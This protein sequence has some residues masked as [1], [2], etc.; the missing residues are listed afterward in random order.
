MEQYRILNS[1]MGFGNHSKNGASP[2][3]RMSKGTL[4]F[5]FLFFLFSFSFENT[6][7]QTRVTW[8]PRAQ[9]FDL[10]FE[11]IGRTVDGSKGFYGHSADESS[12]SYLTR[13]KKGA[14]IDCW[15]QSMYIRSVKNGA[16]Y[17]IIQKE[18]NG[19][20][21]VFDI[22]NDKVI[23][24]FD[25][26][27]REDIDMKNDFFKFGYFKVKKGQ[28]FGLVN[29]SSESENIPCMYD[30][31]QPLTYNSNIGEEC[32]VCIGLNDKFGV[33]NL[34]N[35]NM[36]IPCKYEESFSFY[37]DKLKT[38]LNNKIILID[39]ENYKE[40]N[41]ESF[42]VK[43]AEEEARLEARLEAERERLEAEREEQRRAQ[44]QAEELQRQEAEKRRVTTIKSAE[45]GD[46]LFYSE[47]WSW[48]ETGFWIVE[49]G[50]YEM[51]VT[52]FIERIEGER[53]QLRIG[54][55]TSSSSKR[56]STPTINGVRVSKGDIIWAR[57][58]NDSKWVYGE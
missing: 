24:P 23:L 56:S 41:E 26:E 15:D 6:Y 52:C 5:A 4:L 8:R 46:K 1:V 10:H 49:K 12:N 28:K 16:I 44:R 45:I 30:Y 2:K 31:L 35:K 22:F 11:F 54:D 53:Y 50:T 29:I 39:I 38:K 36:I 48:K 19:G 27:N 42:L 34:R 14:T 32:F 18:K 47:T 51:Y 43:K 3:R 20:W 58:L 55:V 21:G 37:D 13:D 7:S 33:I 57:P 17:I 40:L 9:W 25:Y